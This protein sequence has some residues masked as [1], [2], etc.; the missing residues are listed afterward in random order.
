[1]TFGLVTFTKVKLHPQL[2]VLSTEQYTL[3][4][5]AQGGQIRR[6]QLGQTRRGHAVVRYLCCGYSM[7]K[8]NSVTLYL[9]CDHFKDMTQPILAL[10]LVFIG[11]WQM[12]NVLMMPSTYTI[13]NIERVPPVTPYWEV[14]SICF[15]NLDEHLPQLQFERFQILWSWFA[16]ANMLKLLLLESI[17]YMIP[18]SWRCPHL[19]HLPYVKSVK[20]S[21]EKQGKQWPTPQPLF[22]TSLI[23]QT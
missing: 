10:H 4:F 19:L 3:D 22:T 21:Q 13:L 20:S 12:Q 6:Q 18:H 15:H 17:G 14:E 2:R 7:T 23:G 8:T 16:I 1:M 9:T 5:C 11:K